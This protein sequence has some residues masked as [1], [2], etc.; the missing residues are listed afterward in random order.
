M[1]FDAA[2]CF[3]SKY[4]G[5]S[6]YRC[7]DVSTA[8]F[9][10]TKLFHTIEGGGVFCNDPELLKK[11]AFMRNFGH[12]GPEDFAEVGINGKNSEFH[13]AMGLVNLKYIDGI[14][15]KYRSLWTHYDEQLS[16][17]GLKGIAI[18]PDSTF[19]YAY[20]PVIFE[21]ER[22]LLK[23]VT[24]LNDHDIFPRRY[25]YPPLNWLRYV[26]R[27]S[28]PAC[29]SISPRILALPMYSTL[30]LEQVEQITDLLIRARN[31]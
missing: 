24:I 2:H 23:A 31:E 4:K 29:D 1:I 20:Y 28:L 27:G 25:F 21:T 14:L 19:N 5:K 26:G 18:Q 12:N 3:G 30:S 11:M 6:V 15:T 16:G 22:D 10:A 9:H 7:G 17:L 13:A 8:S